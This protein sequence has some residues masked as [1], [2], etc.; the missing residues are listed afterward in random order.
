M[1]AAGGAGVGFWH[2]LQAIIDAVESGKIKG[3]VDVVISDKERLTPWRGPG[4]MVS[5]QFISTANFS[6][7]EAYDQAVWPC[8]RRKILIW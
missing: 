2:L 3:R 1:D 7:R 8:C 6:G 4:V 5:R